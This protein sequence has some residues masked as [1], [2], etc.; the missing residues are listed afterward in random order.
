MAFN[1]LKIEFC[2]FSTQADSL[3]TANAK[4]TPAGIEPDTKSSVYK[5]DALPLNESGVVGFKSITNYLELLLIFR[6]QGTYIANYVN[7]NY[8]LEL[9]Q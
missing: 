5:T 9:N 8:M 3:Y 1:R 4:N 2:V 6:K 7:K